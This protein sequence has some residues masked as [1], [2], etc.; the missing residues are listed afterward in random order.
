MQTDKKKLKIGGSCK[1]KI[2]M[3]ICTISKTEIIAL[4]RLGHVIM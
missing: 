4:E 2:I 1:N 3:G